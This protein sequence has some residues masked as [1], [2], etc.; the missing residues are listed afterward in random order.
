[1]ITEIAKA[2]YQPHEAF[3]DDRSNHPPT[4]E[5]CFQERERDFRK[6]GKLWIEARWKILPFLQFFQVPEEITVYT[7]GNVQTF[8]ERIRTD[9]CD[10]LA[11]YLAQVAA[12][13]YWSEG[14]EELQHAKIDA[15]AKV[16][17]SRTANPTREVKRLVGANKLSLTGEMFKIRER[18]NYKLKQE[19]PVVIFEDKMTKLIQFVEDTLG[20]K[21]WDLEEENLD[22]SAFPFEMYMERWTKILKDNP[23]FFAQYR[24]IYVPP[25]KPINE[26]RGILSMSELREERVR[27]WIR[28]S[29]SLLKPEDSAKDGDS[30]KPQEDD[31]FFHIEDIKD[32]PKMLAKIISD[33]TLA[34]VDLDGVLTSQRRTLASR[35]ELLLT[36]FWEKVPD[37][38]QQLFLM[39]IRELLAIIFS[40]KQNDRQRIWLLHEDREEAEEIEKNI[41]D[42]QPDSV[43]LKM[44]L[45]LE[46]VRIYRD[47]KDLLRM[48]VIRKDLTPNLDYSF[49]FDPAEVK[50]A[51]ES[52]GF[53]FPATS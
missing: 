5:V 52:A 42:L 38:Y 33:K 34:L 14:K 23:D 17:D 40:I 7:T 31:L 35:E 39:D 27:K 28:L 16:I 41:E 46:P 43:G 47:P 20:L 51:F 29:N 26:G 36:A 1:M 8:D 6:A 15:I 2:Q 50:H 12:L 3:V 53:Q 32:D 45:A 30:N 25:D 21:V 49:Y 9:Y 10:T 11:P 18:L 4:Y 48:R 22:D 13:V 44:I 37:A 24:F 19:T